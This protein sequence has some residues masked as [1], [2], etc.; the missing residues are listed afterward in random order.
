MDKIET[1][2]VL[3]VL[4]AAYPNFYKGMTMEDYNDTVELWATMFVDDPAE[5]VAAAVK[6]HIVSDTKGFPPHIGAIKNSIVK[7]M[8]PKELELSEMEAWGKVRRAIHGSYT[9][10]WSRKFWNGPE[11]RRCSA[12]YYFD[13]LPEILQRIVGSPSQLAAW[14]RVD[15]KEIDTVIQSNFMRSFRARVSHEKEYL[16]LPQDVRDTMQKLSGGVRIGIEAE[17]AGKKGGD[18]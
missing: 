10:E 1:L 15:E 9:E 13:C 2:S 7:L 17:D 8:Q 16:A 5:I 11:D 6:A 4:R 12:E 14:N 18:G 3:S